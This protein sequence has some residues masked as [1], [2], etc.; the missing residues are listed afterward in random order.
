[1]HAKQLRIYGAYN[2]IFYFHLTF[3]YEYVPMLLIFFKRSFL[4]AA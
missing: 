2:S 1:M 4:V 3:N